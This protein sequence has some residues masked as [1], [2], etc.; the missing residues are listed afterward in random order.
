L[1]RNSGRQSRQLWQ[2]PLFL[3]LIN[4]MW[5]WL[6]NY[7]VPMP[8]LQRGD[9][10]GGKKWLLPADGAE[11]SRTLRQPPRSNAQEKATRISRVV[12]VGLVTSKHR[13]QHTLSAAAF[14]VLSRL[15]LS[16]Q[17]SSP[18]SVD[19][20]MAHEADVC[21]QIFRAIRDADLPTARR[22]LDQ[23]MWNINDNACAQRTLFIV[24]LCASR[25]LA[26]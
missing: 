8:S 23:G 15:S 10:H 7:T 9:P 26:F 25:A 22:L 4:W 1:L 11:N 13:T 20:G 12:G 16:A 21:E 18:S 2:K 24:R 19:A 3:R 6:N 5:V 14:G 17:S